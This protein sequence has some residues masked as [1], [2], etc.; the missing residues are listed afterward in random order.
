MP[1]TSPF[2]MYG[3]REA[4]RLA[5]VAGDTVEHFDRRLEVMDGKGM[6]VCMSRRIAIQLCREV[7]RLRPGSHAEADETGSMK[8]VMTGS[9]SHPPE[10][11][12]HIRN[13]PR[14]EALAKRPVKRMRSARRPSRS[15]RL[16]ASTISAR[17]V[18]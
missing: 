10:W 12:A 1:E 18:R 3:C 4:T 16:R 14:R 7:T 13:K 8:V 2:A 5:L 11:Q 15:A 9:A 17:L 6:I